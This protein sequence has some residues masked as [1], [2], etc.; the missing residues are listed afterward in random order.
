MAVTSEQK[1]M[2]HSGT[3]SSDADTTSCTRGNGNN[4]NFIPRPNRMLGLSQTKIYVL[5]SS[6]FRSNWLRHH[7]F[8]SYLHFTELDIKAF[9]FSLFL[10]YIQQSNNQENAAQY[11]FVLQSF[12]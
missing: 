3:D 2:M 7:L 4:E 11:N 1:D 12:E 8:L 5:L 10:V 6:S 9:M